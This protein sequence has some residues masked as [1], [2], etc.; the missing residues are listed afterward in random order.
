MR[1]P[2]GNPSRTG[3]LSRGWSVHEW[4][5]AFEVGMQFYDGPTLVASGQ[6]AGF[7]F[8]ASLRLWYSASMLQ[9]SWDRWE[10]ESLAGEHAGV[11]VSIT[12]SVNP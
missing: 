12:S 3:R 2:F 8:S 9:R 5:V 1:D 11:D 10:V 7:W 4:S 6:L